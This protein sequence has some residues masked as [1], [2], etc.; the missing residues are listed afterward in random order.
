MTDSEQLVYISCV[1]EVRF[2]F[3]SHL[4]EALYQKGI[5]DVFVDSKDGLSEEAQEKVERARVSVMVLPVNRKVCL[6]QLV[7]VLGCRRS[8]YQVVVP[9][10]YGVKRLK[11]L[12]GEWLSALGSLDSKGLSSV[13]KSRY[14][15]SFAI[16]NSPK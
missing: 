7:Q 12:E 4:L 15:F 3:V 6:D 9:V 1:G 8:E 13:H 14:S 11:T 5:N 10:L 16:L 2:S